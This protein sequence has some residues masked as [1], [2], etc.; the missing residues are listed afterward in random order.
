MDGAPHRRRRRKL[1]GITRPIPQ[2]YTPHHLRMVVCATYRAFTRC[3]RSAHAL[4]V[5]LVPTHGWRPFP[6]N[7]LW[8]YVNIFKHDAAWLALNKPLHPIFNIRRHYPFGTRLS[9]MSAHFT[10]YLP[11]LLTCLTAGLHT[12]C[13]HTHTHH[14]HTTLYTHCHTTAHTHTYAYHTPPACL[15]PHAPGPAVF[16]PVSPAASPPPPPASSHL[17]AALAA[18]TCCTTHHTASSPSLPHTPPHAPSPPPHHAAHCTGT[19]LLPAHPPLCHAYPPPPHP[20]TC[21]LGGEWPGS[22]TGSWRAAPLLLLTPRLSRHRRCLSRMAL[23]SLALWTQP[24]TCWHFAALLRTLTAIACM[25][26][27]PQGRPH[28]RVG[29]AARTRGRRCPHA[30]L[31]RSAFAAPTWWARHTWP[32]SHRQAGSGGTFSRRQ[33]TCLRTHT[34]LAATRAPPPP[35]ATTHARPP[36]PLCRHWPVYR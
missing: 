14:V 16:L 26:P 23:T 1:F 29:F 25:S 28:G 6:Q 10:A 3:L 22:L 35:P 4:P 17:S 7:F 27:P 15:L 32:L 33:Q 12:C 9:H 8:F 13:L 31:P 2:P 36:H 21:D 30:P 34:F 5:S 19:H 11:S 18:H 20:H 24:A